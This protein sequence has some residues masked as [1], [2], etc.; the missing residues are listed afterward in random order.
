MPPKLR[1]ACLLL[2]YCSLIFWLSSRSTLP[3]PMLFAHE[4]KLVHAAAYAL[5]G[6]LAWRSFGHWS[7][8]PW[9]LVGI[10]VSFCSLYGA[11]DEWHQSFVPGRDADVFDWLADTLGAT[12]AGVV[13]FRIQPRS[14]IGM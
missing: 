7:P 5:M 12:L 3:L 6:W 8:A 9:L 10:S 11:G 14:S 13:L 4:D 1:D 2:A